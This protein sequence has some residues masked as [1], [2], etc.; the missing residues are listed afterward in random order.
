MTDAS[1]SASESDSDW[2]LGLF[3]KRSFNTSTLDSGDFAQI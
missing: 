1:D 3:W 2:G